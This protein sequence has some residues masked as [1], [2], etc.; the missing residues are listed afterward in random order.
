M[1]ELEQL[2]DAD[3]KRVLVVVAHPDDAEYGTSAAVARWVEQGAEVGYLLLTA[4]E[5]GMKS[6]PADVAP[7]RRGEQRAACEVVGV[8]H[9]TILDHPDGLLEPDLNLRRSI[10]REIRLFQPDV[11]VCTTWE[12]EAGW[13]LNHAD[14]R[15]VGIAT[16]DAIRDADNPWVFNDLADEGLKPW[17]ATWLLVG[18]HS[19][20]T[21]AVPISERQLAKAVASLEAHEA[22]L[23]DLP[24]H[25]A[26]KDF[27][28]GML[29]AGGE[30]LGTEHAMTY[31]VYKLR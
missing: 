10:A 26:P 25:P 22:Y 3:Y 24:D 14:H 13:G 30:R 20:P 1:S 27:I 28:P 11:V 16:V 18:A 29:A 8:K 21:H 12:L 7:L 5:A 6:P 19:R 15:A 23:A 2:Q 31:A 4:G 9:L 17:G